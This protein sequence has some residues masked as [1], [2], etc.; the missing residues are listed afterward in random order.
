MEKESKEKQ[1]KY[2]GYFETGPGEKIIFTGMYKY[3]ETNKFK[4]D[5]TRKIKR[6]RIFKRLYATKRTVSEDMR[7][8]IKAAFHM[9]D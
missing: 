7:A 5:G 3:V 2:K 8:E 6:K 1:D 9:F 4:E